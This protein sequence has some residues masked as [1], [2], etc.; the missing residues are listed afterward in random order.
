VDT[1]IK[2]EEAASTIAIQK[3][4]VREVFKNISNYFL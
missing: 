1:T 2:P 3:A 4:S